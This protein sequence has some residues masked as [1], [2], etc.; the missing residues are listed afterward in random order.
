MA[1]KGK[2]VLITGA[3]SGIGG[4]TAVHFAS[5]GAMVAL[6]GRNVERLNKYVKDCEQKVSVIDTPSPLGIVADVSVDAER[7]IKETIEY[8]GQLDVL[9]NNA[10][11]G[12]P[13]T[14][15]QGS[16]EHFDLLMNTNARSVYHLSMLAL[17]HLIKTKGNIVNVSSIAGHRSFVGLVAYC[18]SKGALDQFTRC[19]SLELAE[20][21]IRVN[22][23]SPGLIITNFHTRTGMDEKTYNEFIDSC[24][25]LY[26][27]GRAG[28][29][30]EVATGIAFLANDATSSFVTGI[31]L[32]IDG[33]KANHCPR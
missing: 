13:A 30:E 1:F 29:P 20:K 3:S 12:G 19:A 26:P 24:K 22:S 33:G 11:I 4:A 21:G 27:L 25:H 8:Y 5:L 31:I 10:G 17:P 28:L 14:L 32:P 15:E 23:V 7:I 6:V 2:V 18:M 9:V 16:L